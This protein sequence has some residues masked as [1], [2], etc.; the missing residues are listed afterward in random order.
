M[1]TGPFSKSG[2]PL[3]GFFCQ[4]C[5]TVFEFVGHCFFKRQIKLLDGGQA[6]PPQAYLGKSGDLMGKLRG[7]LFGRPLRD[8]PV[9]QTHLQRFLSFNRPTGQDHIHGPA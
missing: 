8:D 6:V 4:R 7:G 2:S 1:T 5:Q 3:C 9:N